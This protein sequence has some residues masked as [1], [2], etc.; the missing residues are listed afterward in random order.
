MDGY[1]LSM[2]VICLG[3]IVFAG[4]MIYLNYQVEEQNNFCK[5]EGYDVYLPRHGT[6][7]KLNS[8]GTETEIYYDLLVEAKK[9]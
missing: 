4:S 9:K 1:I 8:D 5:A 7:A 2:T 3:M 6:C